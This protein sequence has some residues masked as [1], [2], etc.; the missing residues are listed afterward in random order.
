MDRMGGVS[1]RA[2]GFSADLAGMQEFLQTAAMRMREDDKSR[3]NKSRKDL[4]RKD[5]RPVILCFNILNFA[6]Y[7][8]SKGLR[9]G[10]R[11]L[12]KIEDILREVFL[13]DLIGHFDADHFAVLSSGNTDA[14]VRAV[15]DRIREVILPNVMDCRIGACE[16]QGEAVP[17]SEACSRA[18][19]ACDSIHDAKDCY[20]T[21]YSDEMSRHEVI[22]SYLLSHID[23]AIENGWIEVYYQ[24]QIRTDTG[25]V[26]GLEALS[27]WND[28]KYG[29]LAPDQFIDALE[30]NELIYKLD[31]YVISMICEQLAKCREQGVPAV[32]VSFN[33]SRM[34]FLRAD[35]FRAVDD[36]VTSHNLPRN[37]LHIEVVERVFSSHNDVITVCLERFCRAGY[38]IWM[39]D[40][41]S[42]FSSLNLLKDFRF[43]VVKLDMGFLRS[44]TP[45]AREIIRSVVEMNGRLGAMSLA[46]GV[47]EEEQ[48]EFLKKIGCHMAQGYFFGKPLPFD[49]CLE[50][51][52]EKKLIIEPGSFRELRKEAFDAEKHR[53]RRANDK[54]E[55]AINDMPDGTSAVPAA[56][57]VSDADVFSVD[58]A[59]FR[60]FLD[61][62]PLGA[63][64]VTPDRTILTWNKAAEKITGFSEEWMLGRRC[65]NSGLRHID[66]EGH[67]LC[68][69]LCPFLAVL[70]DGKPRD[71]VVWG[72]TRDGERIR[73][74][75]YFVPI[76]EDSGNIV[77]IVELFY[78]VDEE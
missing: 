51:L 63:Y 46:E 55:D 54:P 20:F 36:A 33:L 26:C 32:P 5:D 2:A 23:E 41:G 68:S 52:R 71:K 30:E 53:T 12:K 11:L 39:D 25:E 31:T 40:F 72:H 75:A 45:R 8:Y 19:L 48:Y 43:D 10:D 57:K 69:G 56:M 67:H 47:E 13:N 44:D 49:K 7:N 58:R 28:P 17:I 60:L 34:D 29:F 65:V 37:M 27:R 24:P 42:G 22:R 14:K 59:Q 3:K 70:V 6:Y 77:E 38:E 4:S 64:I 74:H 1:E 78:R 66:D 76:C 61:R 35:I 15:Y 16:L 9:E 18:K 62:L 50:H 21:Y 73:L